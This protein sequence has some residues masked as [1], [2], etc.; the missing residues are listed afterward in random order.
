MT[1]VYYD[2]D[3]IEGWWAI[4]GMFQDVTIID[5]HISWDRLMDDFGRDFPVPY[6]MASIIAQDLINDRSQK[7][8]PLGWGR[9]L[10]DLVAHPHRM[11]WGPTI[12]ADM[13]HE[14]HEIIYHDSRTWPYNA[15]LA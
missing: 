9:L 13:Y 12:L 2:H 5:R 4:R 14:L 15:I 3:A 10:V 1:H 8:F 6:I 11:A 7:G